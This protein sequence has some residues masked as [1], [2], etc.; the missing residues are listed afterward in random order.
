MTLAVTSPPFGR[1]RDP[2]PERPDFFS[3]AGE[4]RHRHE[5]LCSMESVTLTD[6][7]FTSSGTYRCEVSTEAPNFETVFKNAN[8]TVMGKRIL[9]ALPFHVIVVIDNLGGLTLSW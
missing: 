2:L 9:R 8:M 3:A 4:L 7:S 5:K 1:P 6:L